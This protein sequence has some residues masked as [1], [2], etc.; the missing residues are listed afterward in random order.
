MNKNLKCLIV[1]DEKNAHYVLQHYID[2]HPLLELAGQCYTAESALDFLSRQQAD[3]VFLDIEM[4]GRD[5]FDLI[6]EMSPAAARIILTTAYTQHALKA[7]NHGVTD[8]LV[9]PIPYERFEQAIARIREV[10][11]FPALPEPQTETLELKTDEGMQLFA[12]S[13][14]VYL[15]SWGNYVKLHTAGA[16]FVCTS[17]TAELEK[18]LPRQ[19]FVRIH[20]SFIVAISQIRLVETELVWLKDMET[21]LP[22]GITYRR[23]LAETMKAV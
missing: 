1:D 12:L 23:T 13:A 9:K 19:Q 11:N 16:V 7:Y 2:R 17:T 22:V 21:R 14:I 3:V 8:Y 6:R 5:G 4:P 18:R 15:Q 20:K 10:R